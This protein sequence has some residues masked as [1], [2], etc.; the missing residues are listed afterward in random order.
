MNV[1]R[2]I[3]IANYGDVLVA[4]WDGSST[5]TQHIISYMEKLGKPVYIH[6]I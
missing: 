4:V 3:D 1:A 2:N 6:R 5:G